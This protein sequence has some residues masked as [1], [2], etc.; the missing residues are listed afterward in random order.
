MPHVVK[1]LV[2]G[3]TAVYVWFQAMH[4]RVDLLLKSAGHDAQALLA[5]A[6]KIQSL[7]AEIEAAGNCFDPASEL[8]RFNSLEPGEHMRPSR[9]LYEMLSLCRHYNVLTQGF[10]DVTVSSQ[11]HTPGM[12]GDVLVEPGG[13]IWRGNRALYINLSGF[14]KGYA[15]DCIRRLLHAEGIRD[16][17]VN[18]GNSSVM[19]LGQT[20]LNLDDGCLT[21]SGNPEGRQLQIVNPLTGAVVGTTGRVEVATGGG[22]EGEVLS[23]VLFIAGEDPVYESLLRSRFDIRRITRHG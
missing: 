20:P 23:T 2:S 21:T 18:M 5:A 3:E 14:I 10:F 7:V 4:T 22:A 13:E 8:S 9:F 19:A 6:G 17:V 16:A 15:L 1:E 11:G 12:A